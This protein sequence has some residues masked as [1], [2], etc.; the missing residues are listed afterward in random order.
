M[1]EIETSRLC[2]FRNIIHMY[3]VL[4]DVFSGRELEPIKLEHIPLL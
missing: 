3:I 4:M 1:G 2:C